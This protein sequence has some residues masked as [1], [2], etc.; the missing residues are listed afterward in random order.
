VSH[1][2]VTGN[3]SHTEPENR[4]FYPA[5]DGLRAVAFL[6]VF[7]QHYLHLAWG[8]TGVNI[9]FVLS[10][11]LITGILF[12]T[13]DDRHRARN[14]Y[15]R[16]T[17]RIF[18]LF[19]GV[20]FL[21]LLLQ[22]IMHWQWTWSWLLWPAYL[23]NFARFLHPS[24]PGS[25]LRLLGDFQLRGLHGSA[26][27]TLYMGHFWSLCVEEQFYL[28]WPWLVFYIR[29]RRRLLWLCAA[30]LP[31][32]LAL[33]LA[34]M[35]WLPAWMLQDEVLLRVMP[36]C[37]D[38]LLLGGLLALLLRGRHA[39]TLL[40][41]AK[42]LLPVALVALVCLLLFT[43]WG[44]LLALPYNYPASVHTWDVTAIN[45]LAALL[46]LCALQPGS[47]LYRVLSVP[48]LRWLGRISYGAY[49]LHDI[50]HAVYTSLG[51]ALS[52]DHGDLIGGII[53]LPCTV[54]LAWLSFRFFESPFLNLKTRWTLAN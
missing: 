44:A 33:R 53:A 7:L 42:R 11:F 52:V 1:P 26:D 14:F 29:D 49:V 32:C 40:L 24:L 21:L 19:Y 8:W 28:L 51:A 20:F 36:F 47:V 22:P 12:D 38:S 3:T 2:I 48:A 17:L 45:L 30:T 23:G 31:L 18:P 35:A 15:I 34:G 39:A 41:T 43:R 13:R 50:P 4:V 27:P 54:L 25:P 5:L 46:V 6:M 16:R 9:F 10:G 37:A